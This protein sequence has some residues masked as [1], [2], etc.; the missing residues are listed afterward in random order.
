MS[1]RIVGLALGIL[2][3]VAG[4][5]AIYLST[6]NDALAAYN[7][8]AA[9]ASLADAEA[10]RECR[11]TEPATIISLVASDSNTTDIY[12][13]FA[14]RYTPSS[15]ATLPDGITVSQ[16]LTVG[17]QVPVEVWGTRVTRIAGI[18]TMDNPVNDPAPGALRIIGFLLVVTGFAVPLTP[19]LW[20]RL[21]KSSPGNA[22]AVADALWR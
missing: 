3:V 17:T 5:A 1:L 9:C 10:G 12:F 8:A 2:T 13:A 6:R 4:C 22:I 21:P 16:N 7:S 15:P 11:I 20:D 19:R 14:G 18:A